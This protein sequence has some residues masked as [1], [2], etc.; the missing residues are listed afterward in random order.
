MRPALL[1]ALFSSATLFAAE[2]MYVS[3]CNLGK[4]PETTVARAKAETEAAFRSAEVSIEWRGCNEDPAAAPW[5]TLRLRNDE[6]PK[7]AGSSSLDAMG[8]AFVAES[9]EG[10]L[11][12]AYFEAIRELASQ[13]QA[14]ARDLWG[15]VMAHELCH[16]LL[17]PGHVPGG[18]MRAK[19]SLDELTALRQQWLQFNPSQQAQIRRGLRAKADLQEAVLRAEK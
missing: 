18:V 10:Y 12:D 7:T 15:Y 13:H 19:W 16:L 5:F 6:P 1:F 3:V 9:G 14:D 17:G 4:L 8:R 11:A 2:P